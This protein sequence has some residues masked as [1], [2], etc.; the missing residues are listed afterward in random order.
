MDKKQQRNTPLPARMMLL[1]ILLVLFTWLLQGALRNALTFDEPSHMAAGYAFLQQGTSGLWTVALRGHPVV[2][3]AWEALPVFITEPDLPVTA[4]Q[5]WGSDRRAYTSEFIHAIQNLPAVSFAGRLPSILCTLILAAV[6]WRG[7]TDIWNKS[8]GF[9]AVLIFFFDPLILAHGR[10]AT[11]DIAVTAFGSL[12]LYGTWRWGRKPTWKGSVILGILLGIT[13]LTK[14]TGVFYG[15]VGLVWALWLAIR[16]RKPLAENR[17]HKVFWPQALVIG[18]AAL[19]IVWGAYGF[20][21]GPTSVLPNLPVPAPLHWEGVFFQADNTEKREVYALGYQKTGRWW[22]YFPLAFILKNPLPLLIALPFSLFVFIKLRNSN[23]SNQPKSRTLFTVPRFAVILLPFFFCVTYICAAL[24]IFPNI[25]Y[26]H[27][28]PVQPFLSLWISGACCL[29][30]M[31][32]PK[33]GRI[34]L[35]GWGIWYAFGTA[36]VFP[37]EISFFNELAG[38]PDQGWRY[39]TTSNTDWLQGWKEL[40]AW[41]KETDIHFWY[42]GPEGYLGLKDYGITYDPLPPVAGSDSPRLSPWLFP[43]P[44][45]YIVG[46][47]ILSGMNVADVDN[48][49]WFRYRE[50]DQV[51]AHSLYYYEV[52]PEE[53]PVWVAQCSVPVI[54]LDQ[55]TITQAYGERTLRLLSFD[56]T[57]SWIYPDG[58]Q[59][60]GHYV[61]HASQTDP[62]TWRTRLSLA[63]PMPIDRFTA[64]HLQSTSMVARERR[65]QEFPAFGVYGW[66]GQELRIPLHSIYAAPVASIPAYL[67]RELALSAPLS[68]H[69]TLTFLGIQSTEDGDTLEV[70]TY[71][72]VETSWVTRP[73]SVMAHLLASDGQTIDIA[74]GLNISPLLWQN[75][76]VIVQRHTF[77]VSCEMR[78]DLWLRTG[79]YWLDTQ[80]RWAVD[81]TRNDALFIPLCDKD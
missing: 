53:A 70:E 52:T 10:L 24:F 28:L 55:A 18:I 50:P 66:S 34:L 4:M 36:V 77:K 56:C 74:D 7:T 37:N 5:G 35:V 44:G 12:Y 39:L 78:K 79:I 31:R 41:Q 47:S 2:F 1:I 59:S 13:M 21:I 30:W 11:N 67:S 29:A 76:D 22:W 58:G 20:D 8:T 15:A 46:S 62:E 63:Q 73:V 19:G 40:Q 65:D 16:F 32:L 23:N 3:N 64:R 26:R 17:Q 57:K 43:L 60:K 42:T 72:R 9:L 54:P 68:L 25:G 51:I 81:D 45:G 33:L 38:G 14:A 69:D 6:L 75:G 80:D 48:Y 27:M 71:W 61:L 49:A